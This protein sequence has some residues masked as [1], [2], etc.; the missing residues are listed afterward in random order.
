MERTTITLHPHNM[1]Y[2]DAMA[3]GNRSAFI[4]QL[5][6]KDRKKSIREAFAKANLEEAM[7]EE[8]RSELRV[9]DAS[10]SDGLHE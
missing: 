10:L 5:I 3:A 2:L 4:N 6:D 8:Q 7:D 9:W 1:L